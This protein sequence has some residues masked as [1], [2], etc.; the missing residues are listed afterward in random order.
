MFSLSGDIT[1]DSKVVD[2]TYAKID[3]GYFRD[4]AYDNRPW[5]KYDKDNK[6]LTF[7]CGYKRT[8]NKSNGEYELNSNYYTPGWYTDHKEDSTKVVLDESFNGARPT[9]CYNWFSGMRNLKEI[10]NLQN[11]NTSEVTN[12][13]SMFSNCSKIQSLDLS[14]FNT[15]KVTD[16]DNMFYNCYKL[17]SLDLSSFNTANVESMRYMF[18]NCSMTAAI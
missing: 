18:E 6:T 5:V 10:E 15:A 13:Y 11:L 14:N 16:M 4:K 9:S 7:Q 17:Q 12:M 3:G 1:Y 8:I 2:K